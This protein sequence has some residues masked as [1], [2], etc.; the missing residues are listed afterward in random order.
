MDQTKAE[1]APN[2]NNAHTEMDQERKMFLEEAIKSMTVDVMEEL[3]KALSILER[4]K[5]FTE[6]DEIDALNSIR[7]NIDSLDF[8]NN[9]IKIGGSKLLLDKIKSTNYKIQSSAIYAI[10]EL[11]QNNTYGQKHFLELN[12]FDTL[13]SL[14]KH[15]S[16]EVASSALHCIS[17]L[18][19]QYEPGCAV[20]LEKNGLEAV[21]EC[22][23]SDHPKVF[24]KACFL[25]SNLTSEHKGIGDEFVKLKAISLLAKCLD[26]VT[27]FDIKIESILL[28][29]N[30][31]TKT[32]K[33]KE[34][35]RKTQIYQQLISIIE[36][37]AEKPECE[38]MLQYSRNLL[39]C[40]DIDH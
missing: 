22:L 38:E 21:V 12:V 14:V 16:E 18:V 9:F 20:F 28:A 35:C 2:C 27:G 17:S 33:G 25:I 19:R 26:I 36:N 10:A 37:N 23:C 32:D 29:L 4:S 5:D 40:F 15:E 3:Q 6:Q 39:N 7:D 8:S 31:L 30:T 13:I 1:D 34:H 11:G 24:T